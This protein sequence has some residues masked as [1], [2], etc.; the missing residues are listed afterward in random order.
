MNFN[1]NDIKAPEKSVRLFEG[2][3]RC[4][5]VH[6]QVYEPKKDGEGRMQLGYAK[7]V[8][9]EAGT[10]DPYNE[11]QVLLI[12]L[13]LSSKAGD[14]QAPINYVTFFGG[15]PK[16]YNGKIKKHKWA[17]TYDAAQA[18]KLEQANT[19]EGKEVLA[20]FYA[21]EVNGRAATN[22]WN[23]FH[24]VA[25]DEKANANDLEDWF[26]FAVEN[27]PRLRGQL[28]PGSK[29]ALVNAATLTS[30]DVDAAVVDNPLF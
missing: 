4:T 25:P 11:D 14:P 23:R 21:V 20:L 6:A 3:K 22:V 5:I 15:Q 10:P 17:V 7:L 8:G 2:V 24:S 19:L 30:A 28:H 13:Q 18:D 16:S 12:G 27:S 29:Y 9:Y 1:E 26:Q